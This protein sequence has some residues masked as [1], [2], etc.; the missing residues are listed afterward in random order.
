MDEQ[1]R[2]NAF[3]FLITLICL[4]IEYF[5]IIFPKLI[6]QHLFIQKKK[7]G[8][9]VDYPFRNLQKNKI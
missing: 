7:M 8:L 6:N 2:T 1:L 9:P 5:N 3:N 4:K